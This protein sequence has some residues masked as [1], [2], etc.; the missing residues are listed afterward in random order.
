MAT[1]IAEA[2][3]IFLIISLSYFFL[4]PESEK[5]SYYR[6]YFARDFL[7]KK[8]FERIRADLLEILKRAS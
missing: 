1:T 6:N 5:K 8:D 2:K 4:L 7:F 3:K